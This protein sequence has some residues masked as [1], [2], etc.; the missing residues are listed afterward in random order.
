MRDCIEYLYYDIPRIN[1]NKMNVEFASEFGQLDAIYLST[2]QR[3]EQEI[4]GLARHI[5]TTNRLNDKI[6]DYVL[7]YISTLLIKNI[8]DHSHITASYV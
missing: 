6:P 3:L 4:L 8:K 5:I 7:P 2:L 1:T